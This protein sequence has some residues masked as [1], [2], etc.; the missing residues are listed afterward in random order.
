MGRSEHVDPE[1]PGIPPERLRQY[2]RRLIVGTWLARLGA[3]LLLALT[4]AG[5]WLVV[6]LV[7]KLVGR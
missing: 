2:R 5:A 6:E 4:I 7:F 3:V 1:L